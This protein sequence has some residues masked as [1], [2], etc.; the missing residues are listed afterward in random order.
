MRSDDHV[1]SGAEDLTSLDYLALQALGGCTIDR[2]EVD[3]LGG[4]REAMV[5][6]ERRAAKARIMGLRAMGVIRPDVADNLPGCKN[7]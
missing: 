7:S 3:F 4:R 2:V 6:P 5:Q 1:R